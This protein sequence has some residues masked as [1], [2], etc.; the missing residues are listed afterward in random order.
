MYLVLT[1]TY[2]ISS[3]LDLKQNKTVSVEINQAR[4]KHYRYADYI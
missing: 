2:Q 1:K 3:M 4:Y